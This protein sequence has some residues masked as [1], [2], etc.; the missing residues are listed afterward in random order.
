M[1]GG[2][3]EM[4]VKFPSAKSLEKYNPAALLLD[5]HK[6]LKLAD[7]QQTQLT[8]LRLQIFERNATLLARYDSVQRDFHMPQASQ[9]RGE[10]P[11]PA[12]DSTRRTAMREMRELRQLADSLQDR[13]RADVRDVLTAL[14]DDTQRKQAA[15]YLDKQDIEFSKEFPAPPQQRGQ[16]DS[17]SM[18]GRGRGRGGA[19]P[20]V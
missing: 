7:A 8:G 19:R 16:G 9:R 12:A 1:A 5:K 13:R 2:A 10:E 15:E 6:K 3:R 18:G 11:S 4:N 17:T 14:A 20:P